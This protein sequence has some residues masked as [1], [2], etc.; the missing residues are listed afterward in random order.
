MFKKSTKK[1]W[2]SRLLLITMILTLLPASAWA[3]E[4]V[5]PVEIKLPDSIVEALTWQGATS[6][7]PFGSAKDYNLFLLGAGS[8]A[9]LQNFHESEGPVAVNGD[10]D[11]CCETH[12]GQLCV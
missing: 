2:L 11:S 5:Q 12:N 8:D 6:S 3:E 10:V 4:P 1:I 9:T 7:N